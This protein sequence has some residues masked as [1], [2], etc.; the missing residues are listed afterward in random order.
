MEARVV[1]EHDHGLALPVLAGVVVPVLLGGINAV[2]DE[3]QVAGVD[4]DFRLAAAGA[5]D[6][7]GAELQFLAAVAALD[8]QHG[9]RVGRGLGHRHVLE[10]AV[11]VARL[12]ADALHLVADEV[13]RELL[14]L[15]ARRAAFEFIRGQV[16]DQ[17]AEV[18]GIDRTG[19]G[20]GRHRDGRWRSGGRRLCVAFAGDQGRTGGKA[21]QQFAWHGNSGIAV[22]PR[23]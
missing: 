7:V 11:A 3:H 14:A 20:V 1:D 16:L 6:H 12:Q 15:A 9:V 21:Q 2:A 5:D 22:E 18:G 10:P 13:D 8:F 23:F 17:F 19:E 4:L